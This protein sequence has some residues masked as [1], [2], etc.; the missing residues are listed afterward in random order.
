MENDVKPKP[1]LK[2]QMSK[3]KQMVNSNSKLAS[4]SFRMDEVPA[5]GGAG[6]GGKRKN[7]KDKTT[8]AAKGEFGRA[9][10]K[11]VNAEKAFG[12][13]H[14]SRRCGGAGTG[15]ASVMNKS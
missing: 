13:L 15:S 7:K 10:K 9:G 1:G 8:S 4:G 11:V 12:G 2:K 5:G 14:C 3:Q 6:A